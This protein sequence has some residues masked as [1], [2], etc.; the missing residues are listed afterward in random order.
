M[1]DLTANEAK[2]AG[3]NGLQTYVCTYF[4]SEKF[5]IHAICRKL[6]LDEDDIWMI[7]ED[8][9]RGGRSIIPPHDVPVRSTLTRWDFREPLSLSNCVV[10]EFK[11]AEKHWKRYQ[12]GELDPS[13]VWGPDVAKIVERRKE[14]VKRWRDWVM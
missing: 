14:E 1:R 6:P 9:H 8:L 12:D 3:K 5:C 11:D 13:V 2:L 7:F 10:M 4:F